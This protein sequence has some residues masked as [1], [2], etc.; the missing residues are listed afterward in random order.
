MSRPIDASNIPPKAQDQGRESPAAPSVNLGKTMRNV[1]PE[2]I[3]DLVSELGDDALDPTLSGAEDINLTLDEPAPTPSLDQLTDFSR[4]IKITD[5][6]ALR[7]LSKVLDED[8]PAP[9]SHS[10]LGRVVQR[11]T[12]ELARIARELREDAASASTPSPAPSGVSASGLSVSVASAEQST[13]PV[14][15]ALRAVRARRPEGP[16]PL[17]PSSEMPSKLP[18]GP[19][20]EGLGPVVAGPRRQLP[21]MIGRPTPADIAKGGRLAPGTSRGPETG[22]DLGRG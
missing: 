3:A 8:A 1:A 12:P 22:G 9:A 4:R 13:E 16:G 19:I 2:V 6:K 5:P 14:G 21:P 15:G 20:G 10:D 7:A 18:F 11:I 17:V